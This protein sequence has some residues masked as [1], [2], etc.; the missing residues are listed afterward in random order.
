MPATNRLAGALAWLRRESH[1]GTQEQAPRHAVKLLRVVQLVRYRHA[2]QVRDLH[3]CNHVMLETLA[4]LGGDGHGT[5]LH[6][7]RHHIL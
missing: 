7:L 1:H 6:T 3:H 5:E 4:D 2:L